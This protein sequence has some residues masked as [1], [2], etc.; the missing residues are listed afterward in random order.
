MI[1]G[2]SLL[3]PSKHL[4]LDLKLSDPAEMWYLLSSHNLTRIP[5]I[6][7]NETTKTQYTRPRARF[8]SD[9]TDEG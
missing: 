4:E 8:E 7:W 6:L 5:N 9:L 2:Q 3:Q 1:L